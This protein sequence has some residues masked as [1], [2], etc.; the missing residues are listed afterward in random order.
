MCSESSFVFL[1]AADVRGGLV[2]VVALLAETVTDHSSQ[3]REGSDEDR[4]DRMVTHLHQ[5]AHNG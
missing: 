4:D 5:Y 3:G 2:S 1:E